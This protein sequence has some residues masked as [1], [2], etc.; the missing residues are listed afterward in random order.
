MDRIAAARHALF[1]HELLEHLKQ[2]LRRAIHWDSR[3]V[4][5]PRKRSSVCFTADSFGRHLERLMEIEEDG[6]YMRD[7]VEGKPQLTDKAQKLLDDHAHFRAEL[8]HLLPAARQPA[9]LDESALQQFC[10]RCL[11]LLDRVDAHDRHEI[12]LYQ[13]GVLSEEGSGD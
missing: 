5:L 4:G 6:G 13:D 1:E 2:A 7:I 9:S 12:D 3:E 10:A 11:K 8:A